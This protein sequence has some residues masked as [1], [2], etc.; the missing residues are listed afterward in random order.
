MDPIHKVTIIPRGMALGVTQTLPE[1]DRL[2]LT[3]DKAHNMIAFL[4]GG[5]AAE[6]IIFTDFTTGAANDIER[7]TQL[8]RKMVCEWGMSE[9]LGPLHYEKKEEHVFL[10]LQQ[11]HSNRD[12]SD[13]TAQE[14]DSE[15]KKFVT[16]GHEKAVQILKDNIQILHNLAQA[17]LEKETLD[18]MEVEMIMQG[19]NLADIE[20]ERD[21]RAK[22][23]EEQNKKQEEENKRKE[24]EDAKIKDDAI[25][26]PSGG[27]MGNPGP[28]SV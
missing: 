9:K 19:K 20:R 16:N 17:L 23:L 12:Y 5:R 27:G 4:F 14:I 2:N 22:N 3:K 13:I 1:E 25:K 7:A 26:K 21:L 10:G 24:L 11:G 6:E 15:V 8:A 28:I 18:G